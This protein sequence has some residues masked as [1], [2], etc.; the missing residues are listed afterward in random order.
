MII[1]GSLFNRFQHTEEKAIVISPRGNYQTSV[2]LA[3]ER[4]L[5]ALYEYREDDI[6]YFVF[7]DY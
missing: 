7:S 1:L 4:N 5:K 3:R 6:A 2:P